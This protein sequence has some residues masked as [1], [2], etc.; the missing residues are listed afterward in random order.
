MW[1]NKIKE[2]M[3]DIF[4]KMGFKEL[5]SCLYPEEIFGDNIQQRWFELR[6]K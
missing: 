1:A 6:R 3:E 5:E 2:E 4:E